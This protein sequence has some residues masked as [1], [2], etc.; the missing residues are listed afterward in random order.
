MIRFALL[1][2]AAML[3]GGSVAQAATVF[4]EDFEGPPAPSGTTAL[5]DDLGWTKS[6]ASVG[7]NTTVP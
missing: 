7:Y 1:S 3:L 2:V 4:L 5:A 6:G